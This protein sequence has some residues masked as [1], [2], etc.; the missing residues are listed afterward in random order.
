M[1]DRA[2]GAPNGLRCLSIRSSNSMIFL[3]IVQR[4]IR[5]NQHY[6]KVFL[7][8]VFSVLTA[9][10]IIIAITLQLLLLISLFRYYI[11]IDSS[12]SK[13]WIFQFV[14]I[15][16][17]NIFT[18]SHAH[19][20]AV[21]D[22]H[23]GDL[24]VDDYGDC[25]VPNFPVVLQRGLSNNKEF[26]ETNGS[27]S[28]MVRLL[29]TEFTVLYPWLWYPVHLATTLLI[30]ISLDETLWFSWTY[31]FSSGGYANPVGLDRSL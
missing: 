31:L 3:F 21:M 8:G 9:G 14:A 22:T 26:L 18:L 7:D 25:Q 1:D 20:A 24:E 2:I 15:L 27:S 10:W 13:L 11:F 23:E 5:Q 12:S 28:G 16:N 4:T 29:P 19:S 6:M 17:L 30:T